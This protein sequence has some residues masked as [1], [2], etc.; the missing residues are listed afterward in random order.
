MV[1][2]ALASEPAPASKPSL[3][4]KPET[5]LVRNVYWLMA[6]AFRAIDV[7]EY[8]QIGSEDFRGMEDLLAAILLLGV[9]SQRRRGFERGYREVEEDGWRIHGHIDLRETSALERSG[10]LGA[11]YA[12][13]EYDEDTLLNRILKTC[14]LALLRSERVSQGR[15]VRLKAALGWLRDVGVVDDPA[16]IPWGS[17]RYHRN[18]RTYELLMNVCYLVVENLILTTATG[19][20]RLAAFDDKQWFSTLYEHFLLEYYR[21]HF[22]QLRAHAESVRPPEGAPPFVP[23]MLTD[24]TLSYGGK[25]LILDAKCYG[26]ILTMHYDQGIL[27]AEHVRQI[28]YYATHAGAPADASAALV[29]AGTG[30]PVDDCDWIDQGYSLG[31]RVLDL[32]VPFADIAAKLDD[33]AQ[34]AFS[35]LVKV[36]A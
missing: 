18:N 19:P 22:P 23:T 25:T 20:S 30:E 34:G 13:D 5:V 3:A 29:Y 32:D 21:R 26:R 16:R 4:S 14:L 31:C 28:Y 11:H 36:G 35:L 8:R 1:D 10:R 6:Y 2:A 15:R 27:S 17:L 24:V 12:Y 9:E 7:R 33:I